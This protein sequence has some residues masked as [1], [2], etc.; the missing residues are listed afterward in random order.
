MKGVVVARLHEIQRDFASALLAP[1]RTVPRSIGRPGGGAIRKRFSVYRNN[2][3]MSL[4]EVLEA[5]FPVVLRLLGDEFFRATAR[6]FIVARPPRSPVLSQY[7]AEFPAFLADFEPVV[8]LA[9]LPDVARLEWMQQRAYHAADAGA[10]SARDLAAVGPNDVPGLRLGFH[11]SVGLLQSTF[12]VFSIWR[13]NSFDDEVVAIAPDAP[14][15]TVLV[16]RVGLE[17]RTAML[18]PGG[19]GFVAALMTGGRLGDAAAAGLEASSDFNLQRCIGVLIAMDALA[20]IEGC[21]T[22]SRPRHL[23]RGDTR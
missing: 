6:A 2:V 22:R 23:L 13:T 12:P 15:Q 21:D 7:G 4:T 20:S 14:G 5:Y 1:E 10:L 17:V 11:P 3:I 8:D 9:Y 16:S 18:P 19:H